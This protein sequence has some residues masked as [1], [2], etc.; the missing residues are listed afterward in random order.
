M[1]QGALWDPDAGLV[2]PRS[3]TVAGELV[4]MGVVSGKLQSFANTSCTGLKIE[5]GHI[6][7]VETNR[8]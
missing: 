8:G 1:I 6:K 2:I 5:D 3:Q 7:G 4:E